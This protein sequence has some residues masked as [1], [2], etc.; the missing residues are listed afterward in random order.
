MATKLYPPVIDGVLPAFYL[1]YSSA[2]AI[3]AGGSLT[4][5]FTMNATVAESQVKGFSLRIRTASTG[6]YVLPPI[7]S[8]IYSLSKGEVTFNFSPKQASAFTEG[9]YYKIQIAYCATRIVD[10]AGN[11][12]GDDIGFYSTV[13]VAKCTSKAKVTIR[14]LEQENINSFNNEFYGVYDLTDC[15]DRTEKVYSYEFKVYDENENVFF[16]SGE[17]LHKA[18]YD[19]DYISSI[20]RIV[21]NDFASTETIYSI[22]YNV[23]TINGLQL[24]SP[25]YRITS[26]FLVSSNANISILPEA[27]EENGI[28]IVHFKGGPDPNRSYHYVINE[29]T[30]RTLEIDE[31]GNIKHDAAGKS[32][33]DLTSEAIFSYN[34]MEKLAYLR[35]HTLF[36]HYSYEVNDYYY[37]YLTN[38]PPNLTAYEGRYYLTEDIENVNVTENYLATLDYWEKIVSGRD[39]LK[40]MTYEYV[41]SNFIDLNKLIVVASVEAES[42]YYGSYLL[43]RA[44]DEDNY[45]T[46][47]NVARFKLDDQVPSTFSLKDITIE[48][49]HKYKYALQQYNIW[50]LYSARMISDVFEASFEDMFLFDGEKWLKIRYNPTV[51]T[52]KTTILEQKT[53]TLGGKYPFITRNGSTYYK[54]FPIGGLLAHE[55]DEYHYF[56]DPEWE[57]AHRHGSSDDQQYIPKNATWNQ[58]D[59]SD[60]TI[61]IERLFK[62]RVLEWL[63][64]GKPKLFKS[65]YEGNYI[66]RLL[67]NTLT[68]VKELGRMLH[69]FT[70][71]AYEIA[72]CNYENLVAYGFITTNIPSDLIGLWRSYNLQD[73]SLL[74][75]DGTE[76]VISLDTGIKNFTIQDMMPGDMIYLTFSEEPEEM[77]IMIGITGSYTYENIDKTL[78]KIRIPVSTEH[79]MMGII[80]CFYEGMRITDFD[81]ITNMQLKTV[82]S[83]QY[84]GTSPWMQKLKRVK[85]DEI[86]GNENVYANEI[87]EAQY[88]ELQN[89]NFRT[90]LDRTVTPAGKSTYTPSENFAKLARSFDPGELLE[91]MNLSIHQN[92]KYKTEV[93]NM[94]ILRFRERPLIPVYTT[95]K[96][97]QNLFVP[98]SYSDYF[99]MEEQTISQ[100]TFYVSTTPYGYPHPIEHLAELE[101]L[102]PFCVFQVF[103]HNS[104]TD[105]WIPLNE[106]SSTRTSFY[107]PFYRAWMYEDYDPEVKMDLHWAQ[108]ACL[109]RYNSLEESYMNDRDNLEMKNGVVK[110]KE[111]TD[112]YKDLL[113]DSRLIQLINN[114]DYLLLSRDSR[115]LYRRNIIHQGN[116]IKRARGEYIDQAI[117]EQ[118]M[119]DYELLLSYIDDNEISHYYYT[120][121]DGQIYSIKENQYDLYEK[122]ND[123]YFA[124]GTTNINTSK[125]YWIKEY[126]INLN[127][128]TEKEIEYR[129]I[130]LYNSYHIGTGVIAE[131][132]FQLRIIDYYTEIYDEDVRLAKE[133]YLEAKNFYST[134]METYN[135]IRKANYNSKINHALMELYYRLLFGTRNTLGNYNYMEPEDVASV[136]DT[137]NRILS[138]K[139]LKLQSL[140]NITMINSAYDKDA[141]EL[142]VE[143][144]DRI[145]IILKEYQDDSIPIEDKTYKQIYAPSTKNLQTELENLDSKYFDTQEEYLNAVYILNQNLKNNQ[146]LSIE[147]VFLNNA[148]VYYYYESTETR[149]I[150]QY[151]VLF[152]SDFLVENNNPLYIQDTAYS[153]SS[154]PYVTYRYKY[155]KD[156]QTYYYKVKKQDYIDHAQGTNTN[157]NDL[158]VLYDVQNKNFQLGSKYDIVSSGSELQELQRQEIPVIT[159]YID[160]LNVD[161]LAALK[162]EEYFLNANLITDNNYNLYELNEINTILEQD[163]LKP[164]DGAS[165]KLTAISYEVNQ[166]S[167]E[168]SER[169]SKVDTMTIDY[170]QA[171]LNM[172]KAIDE[173][174]KK[175]YQEWCAELLLSPIAI[176][177]NVAIIDQYGQQTLRDECAKILST[178]DVSI[179]TVYVQT[180][181][182]LNAANNLYEAMSGD[183]PNLEVYT[184]MKADI[185]EDDN[186]ELD[187]YLDQ[188]IANLRGKIVVSFLAFYEALKAAIFTLASGQVDDISEKQKLITSLVN[189]IPKYNTVYDQLVSDNEIKDIYTNITNYICNNYNKYQDIIQSEKIKYAADTTYLDLEKLAEVSNLYDDIC[190]IIK[191]GQ[192]PLINQELEYQDTETGERQNVQIVVKSFEWNYNTIYR[193]S[194]PSNTFYDNFL[195]NE[196]A[197][198]YNPN[199]N[200]LSTANDYADFFNPL[201]NNSIINFFNNPNNRIFRMDY[202]N[203]I[204]LDGAEFKNTNTYF[205]RTSLIR[206]VGNENIVGNEATI[207]KYFIF[208]PLGTQVK[209]SHIP[210][211]YASNKAY[212]DTLTQTEQQE[213]LNTN[214]QLISQLQELLS[215]TLTKAMVKQYVKDYREERNA[216]SGTDNE[217]V[218]GAVKVVWDMVRSAATILGP[219]HQI[220]GAYQK[221]D[222]GIYVPV[223]VA[224]FHDLDDFGI[225]EFAQ[226]YFCIPF[227]SS[228][229]E[230]IGL[231]NWNQNFWIPDFVLETSTK[232]N[233]DSSYNSGELQ[234]KGIY[235]DFI[236]QIYVAR[237]NELNNLL[238]NAQ[239]LQRL[240]QKQVDVYTGKYDIYSIE[241]ELNQQLYSSYSG[242]EAFDYYTQL[243]S[244]DLKPPERDALIQKYKGNVQLAWWAFLNLLDARYSAEK[245]RGMYL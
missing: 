213:V 187:D 156:G 239:V 142:L 13:G 109:V 19:T 129:N 32:I 137:I 61:G 167:E 93:V 202:S 85:W 171:Y 216:L 132:T 121:A 211:N 47:F 220:T 36:K 145:K 173:Y 180:Q 159:N 235:W 217:G 198:T 150:D 124:I 113:T 6:S 25:K 119:Y 88:Q 35:T 179:S 112:E 76:I 130:D 53:D 139:E 7:Y 20:D 186:H 164:L 188:Q 234:E 229:S 168:L 77:P 80:N 27:D 97:D 37:T 104:T 102:D 55:L 98:G 39:L 46:W 12:S 24:S 166:L 38:Y 81:S 210:N 89:Y 72:E 33:K 40:S 90:F 226:P 31:Y 92:D 116:K 144:K 60:A 174:N 54:E 43:S 227:I 51:D 111:G 236:N 185:N 218:S 242:T 41:E 214:Q 225:K 57:H 181:R 241:Y 183:I 83:Q 201:T 45:T 110:L 245:E 203:K 10:E 147:N 146:D 78:V 108:V 23:T 103:V 149:I 244:G 200:I 230:E 8:N 232:V 195:N 14:G 64:D 207:F 101:M 224:S 120:S 5:P 86:V 29:A 68:P 95:Q 192:R 105:T 126:S 219:N 233:A 205:Y 2:G 212:F 50:G 22:E 30:L 136:N 125:T 49:G 107:D 170:I 18:Y 223:T 140:Y 153:D 196:D 71:Q 231:D 141:L 208:N 11:F 123:L 148:E 4:V 177:S 58:R 9:Q 169:Q 1:T 194:S 237:A 128:T 52:F 87:N 178:S 127:M 182:I 75:E 176:G 228:L 190:Y 143:L 243:E 99:N 100:E 84:I 114:E 131:A 175:V 70:S 160:L 48:H 17:I 184:K 206:Y 16:T 161:E 44:S 157:S 158:V 106:I 69:S 154:S 221:N 15:K 215:K 240:Y 162:I 63:N 199:S 204:I 189:T 209:D 91:R 222:N 56:V 94:E 34:N 74:N 191:Q 3:L 42:K 66:V 79:K 96:F 62:L 152:T 82:I 238:E 163:P 117:N 151:Y 118:E 138:R 155:Y 26:Q 115:Y 165:N 135:T 134:L 73:E 197:N 59:F 67:H 21:V 122:V 65:P 28:I 172:L 193:N 133:K